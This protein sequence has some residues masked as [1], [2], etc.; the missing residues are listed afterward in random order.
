MKTGLKGE[1]EDRYW[2]PFRHSHPVGTEAIEALAAEL[3]QVAASFRD[4]R[5]AGRRWR[6][7]VMEEDDPN[8]TLTPA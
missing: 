6:P 4:Q 1:R 7:I 8:L 2:P 3:G 5:Q